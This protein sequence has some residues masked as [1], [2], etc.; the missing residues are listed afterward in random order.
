MQST[1]Y[2]FVSPDAPPAA[3]RSGHAV[4]T[5]THHPTVTM[6]PSTAL[7]QLALLALLTSAAQGQSLYATVNGMD[8]VRIDTTDPTVVEPIGPLGLPAGIR[9]GTIDYHPGM[10]RL[11]GV[12]IE[13]LPQANRAFWLV[14]IDPASG[15]GALVDIIFDAASVGQAEHLEY[16]DSLGEL[17]LAHSDGG[18]NDF[19]SN[20][21]QIVSTV[22]ASLTF[23]SSSGLDTDAGFFDSTQ[24]VF[25]SLD[26]NG[27]DW[28]ALNL[29]TGQSTAAGSALDSIGDLAFDA[30]TG[31]LIAS[32]FS[33][34]RLYTLPIN[35]PS[36]IGA[37]VLLGDVPGQQIT[38]I[39]FAPGPVEVGSPYCGP[40]VTNSTGQSA[41][42]RA[43]GSA[44]VADNQLRILG[45][46][47]PP[48][49]FSLLATSTSIGTLTPPGSQGTLCLGGSIGRYLGFVT[50]SAAYGAVS[51]PV[52][53]TRVPQPSSFVAVQP[54]ETWRFQLWFRDV[55]PNVTSNFTNAVAVTFQ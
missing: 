17:V 2:G 52:D 44:V 12:G 8:L 3:S 22:D 49:Q 46:Q 4:L 9:V 27:S 48:N 36:A 34:P 18:Q 16:V 24:S 40:A 15:T 33:Q 7:R 47:L 54:G 32:D 26:P 43:Y 30:T 11:Y 19:V 10:Q 1:V 14:E 50:G 42:I 21:Y 45:A 28:S 37:A 20:Q 51:I 6:R 41:V 23:L 29:N 53:L 13:D 55:N 38:G 39:A 31:T 5:A 25:F 35:G